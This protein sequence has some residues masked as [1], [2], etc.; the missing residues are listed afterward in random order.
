MRAIVEVSRSRTKTSRSGLNS[1]TNS[2]DMP[3]VVSLTTP[4]QKRQTRADTSAHRVFLALSGVPAKLD[5]RARLILLLGLRGEAGSCTCELNQSVMGHLETFDAT[6]S[7]RVWTS[8]ECNMKRTSRNLVEKVS[9]VRVGRL[10]QSQTHLECDLD[11]ASIGCQC[12]QRIVINGL[13]F[14]V[15]FECVECVM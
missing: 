3:A 6:R 8:P 14:E 1:K 2:C 12:S 4:T 15:V 5:I 7:E 13:W 10:F 9:R 11:V